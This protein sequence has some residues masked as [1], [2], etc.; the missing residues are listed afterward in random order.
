MY[1]VRTL[2]DGTLYNYT[3]VW[4]EPTNKLF[5]FDVMAC[6]DAHILLMHY[7]GNSIHDVYEIV[8]GSHD[9][10]NTEIRYKNEVGGFDIFA[11]IQAI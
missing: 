7:P 8:L 11:I 10:T 6:K 5:T 3:Y 9:G 2:D 4:M 1:V